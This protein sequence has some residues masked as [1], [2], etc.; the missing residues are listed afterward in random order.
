MRC[1]VIT[2]AASM[3][4]P[5]RRRSK[6]GFSFF[7]W[8]LHHSPLPAALACFGFLLLQGLSSGLRRCLQPYWQAAALPSSC[9]VR[10][11]MLGLV[12]GLAFGCKAFVLASIPLHLAFVFF[13]S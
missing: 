5:G 10:L 8:L 6:R 2:M 9:C 13:Y 7:F 3:S 4:I 1:S 12:L 11:F